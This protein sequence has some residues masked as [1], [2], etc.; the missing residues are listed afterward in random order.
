MLYFESDYMEGAHEKLLQSLSKTNRE[1][2]SGYGADKYC[3][4]AKDKIRQAIGCPNAEIFFLVG[5]TQTNKT[6]IDS[7]L[8]NYEGVVSASTG[9]VECHEAGAIE[10]SRHKVLTIP[11]HDGK[12]D[13]AELREYLELF[14]GD[15]SH[16]HMV[17]PGM[18]YIS[19]PTEYGTLYS[20]AELESIK[21]VCTDYEM[22]LYLDGA[23]LGYGLC[24]KTDVTIKDIARICDVFYIGGTKC[25]A[26]CG[27]AVVFTNIKMPKHFVTTVKQNGALLAKGRLLGVQFGTLFTD[28]LYTEICQN[29]LDRACELR[30]ALIEKGYKFLIDSPTNQLFPI[31][32]NSFM[33][34]L[35]EKVVFSFWEKYDSDHTVIRFATSWATTKEEVD[36]LISLL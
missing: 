28:N 9:H 29:A 15:S 7:L 18:V 31:L 34:K 14:Y 19:H 32:E 21:A 13:A 11:H 10:A 16:E 4:E 30:Q 23:R 33:E 6:V 8:Q 36:E 27:E 22:P 2:L 17:F 24:A 12:I 20:K 26:I 5:G 1:H 3:D 25:G 35:S